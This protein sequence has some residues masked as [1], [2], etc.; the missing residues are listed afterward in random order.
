MWTS[1]Q[2]TMTCISRQ[3][4]RFYCSKATKVI[5]ARYQQKQSYGAVVKK[6][7]LNQIPV[8]VEDSSVTYRKYTAVNAETSSEYHWLIRNHQ[9][10]KCVK[11]FK[12]N[13]ADDTKVIRRKPAQKSS[14][15]SAPQ[16]LQATIT[17]ENQTNNNNLNNLSPASK[18]SVIVSAQNLLNEFVISN[19][20]KKSTNDISS[21]FDENSLKSI[22]SY[23]MM[24]DKLS[25]RQLNEILFDK[26]LPSISKVLQATMP[27]SARI[28]LERWKLGK[29][30]ELGEAGFNRYQQETLEMGRQFHLAIETYLNEGR[31]PPKDSVVSKLWQ[32]LGTQLKD[33]E[34][35]PVMV[36]KQIIH[37]DLKYKGIIDNVS[38]VK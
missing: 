23:S 26:R 19:R 38:Y 36:E 3:L 22:T 33:L 35:S 28:A 30:A 9:Q 29:I 18:Q 1:R 14:P 4:S 13:E 6:D 27:E 32:S 24:S 21:L 5:R 11:L 2:P 37:S 7:D 17:D 10:S 31:E 25:E 15:N 12:S 34:P 8:D 16:T 20:S